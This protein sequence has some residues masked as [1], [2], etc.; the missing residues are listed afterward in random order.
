MW[1][2]RA[3][4]LSFEEIDRLVG[5]FIGARRRPRPPHRRRAALA[6][7][8]AGRRARS[9]ARPGLAEP[10]SR[11]TASTSPRAAAA[12]RQRRPRSRHRQ[13]RHAASSIAS[14]A[15]APREPAAVLAGL[16]RRRRRL[17]ATQAR[18]RGHP[19]RERR[20]GRPTC[21]RRRRGSARRSV[22]RVHGRGRRRPLVGVRVVPRDEM[23]ARLA[24]AFGPAAPIGRLDAAR[25]RATSCPADRCSASSPRPRPLLR[26]LRSR[27]PHR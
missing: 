10:R 21:A 26:R 8:L 27:A 9:R 23:L 1:L 14:N 12:L 3:D 5:V 22:H 13:P 6:P 15:S 11:P 19:R 17:R 24:P 16:E 25:P 2:P 18:H 4:L 20:R 7:R